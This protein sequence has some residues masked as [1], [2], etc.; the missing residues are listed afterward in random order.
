[1]I[2]TSV[3]ELYGSRSYISL[4][5]VSPS[6]TSVSADGSTY[7]CFAFNTEYTVSDNAYKFYSGLRYVDF[8]IIMGNLVYRNI[9]YQEIT[10]YEAE[11]QSASSDNY[12]LFLEF[13]DPE[14]YAFVIKIYEQNNSAGTFKMKVQYK[15][16]F[17][18]DA[19]D[20]YISIMSMQYAL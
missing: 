7:D 16:G 20:I 14:G 5:S 17:S 15:N 1:M 4:S 10:P 12:P 6:K 18:R 9:K 13:T 8:V 19:G 2:P 11:Y 3:L